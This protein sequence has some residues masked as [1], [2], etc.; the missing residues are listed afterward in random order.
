M[1]NWYLIERREEEKKLD[2]RDENDFEI[3]LGNNRSIKK[4]KWF[5]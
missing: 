4:F 1:E 2:K 5:L 3:S